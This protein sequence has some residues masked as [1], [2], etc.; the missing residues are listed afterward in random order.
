MCEVAK[1]LVK[2]CED[3]LYL[4]EPA[5]VLRGVDKTLAHAR[6]YTRSEQFVTPMVAVDMETDFSSESDVLQLVEGLGH[7]QLGR[8]FSLSLPP[9]FLSLP[10]SVSLSLSLPPSLSLSLSLS[11]TLTCIFKFLSVVVS[12]T[13]LPTE[14][15]E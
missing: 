8:L 10:L 2:D 4:S 9:L 3:L 12:P 15:R 13:Q 14:W 5:E 1:D 6:Q 11:H 7:L